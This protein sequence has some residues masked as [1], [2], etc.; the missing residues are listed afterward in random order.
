MA[1]TMAVVTDNIVT[2][3]VWCPDNQ[4]ETDTLKNLTDRTTCIGGT[5]K[6]ED[7]TTE[8][9]ARKINLLQ[10]ENAVLKSTIATLNDENTDMKAALDILGVS[11]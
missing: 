10:E 6:Q 9:L 3:L 4:K 5:Y 8:D 1:K 11:K 7:L 2:N